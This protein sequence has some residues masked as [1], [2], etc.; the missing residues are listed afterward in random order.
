VEEQVLDSTKV[1]LIIRFADGK[2]VNFHGMFALLM[3]NHDLQI[4]N[5]GLMTHEAFKK[6]EAKKAIVH[7]DTPKRVGMMPLRWMTNV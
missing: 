7:G 4:L 2:E 3:A 1:V 5:I 6:L